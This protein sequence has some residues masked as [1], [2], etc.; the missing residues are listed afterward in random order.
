MSWSY[1]PGS[2][3]RETTDD[4]FEGF[5][6]RSPM[7]ELTEG[8]MELI[9]WGDG[10]EMWVHSHLKCEGQTC[11]IHNPSDHLMKDWRQHWRADRGLME[12]LCV[13]GVGHPDPDDIAFKARTRGE[14]SAGWESVHGCD[15]CCSGRFPL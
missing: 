12:R 3:L 9:P 10:G 7:G 13:H 6:P 2:L 4:D 15:G 11:C 5:R 14:E 1:I 8:E